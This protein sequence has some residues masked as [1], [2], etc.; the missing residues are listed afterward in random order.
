MVSFILP[1]LA[2]RDV[3]KA[4]RVHQFGGP[5]VMKVEEVSTPSPG[6]NQVVVRLRA[7][8]VNPVDTY[9]RSGSNPALKLPYTPG[10]DGAGLIES[11][12]ANVTSVKTGDRVY[13]GGAVSG[14]YAEFCLC[15][16]LQVHPLPFKINFLQGA[17]LHVPYATAYRALF[18]RAQ[19]KAGETVLIHGAS[20]GVGIA[21]VQIAKAAGFIVIG[22][23]G[24]EKGL[25][26]VHQE[27]AHHVLNHHNKDYLEKVVAL[28]NGRGV[29]VILEML[30]N[31]NLAKDLPLLSKSGRVVVIGSRGKIE[32]TPRDLMSRDADVRGIMLFN[33]TAQELVSIHSAIRAGLENGTLRPIIGKQMPLGDASQAHVAVLEPGAY[34]KIVLIP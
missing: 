17:A 29:D 9:L 5:E 10:I 3:M 2:L 16:E 31:V 32:I 34:G 33:A 14:A 28:T 24:T 30:A 23:A 19:G 1:R 25:Q 20:G 4:I 8:G 12:G 26:L 7:I 22:T 11:V 13:F 18:H 21:G 27:G 6:A 15:D